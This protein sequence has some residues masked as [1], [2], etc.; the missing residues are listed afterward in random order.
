MA[1]DQP[2]W[3]NNRAITPTPGAAIFPARGTI[4]QIFYYGLD[5]ATE[6]LLDARGIFLYK[7]P[8]EAYQLKDRVLLE[9]DWS[10]YIKTKPLRKTIAFAEGSDNSKLMEKMEALTNKIDSQF[11]DIKGEMKELL[12]GCN[13]CRVAHPSL[14]C[15]DKS[16]G[17]PG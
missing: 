3:E 5:D 9:L 14:E 1:D 11:K 6:A 15:Y 8:N 13:D 2:M 12:D 7:T 17:G 4:I 16:M 10:N